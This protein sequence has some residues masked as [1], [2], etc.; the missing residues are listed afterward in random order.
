M[1]NYIVLILLCVLGILLYNYR[2]IIFDTI[3]YKKPKIT[4]QKIKSNR[5][6]LETISD[7]DD[8]SIN[9]DEESDNGTSCN[10]EETD[11]E[12]SNDDNKTND[13]ETMGNSINS[14]LSMDSELSTGD[15]KSEYETEDL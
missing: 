12:F 15:E 9:L 2:D 1:E 5:D 11:D 10:E 7:S 8:S 13:N 4:M 6:Y 3:Q 14:E